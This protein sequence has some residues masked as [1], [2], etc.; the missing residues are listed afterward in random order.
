[1]QIDNR[2][3]FR[4]LSPKTKCFEHFF[5]RS[6]TTYMKFIRVTKTYCVE[7]TLSNAKLL[8]CLLNTV[9]FLLNTHFEHSTKVCV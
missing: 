9:V 7:S 4:A 6:E 5:C 8:R 2:K 1:M 3:V